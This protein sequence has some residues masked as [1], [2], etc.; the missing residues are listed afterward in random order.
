LALQFHPEIDAEGLKDWLIWGGDKNVI[1]DGQDP[2]IMLAQTVAEEEASKQ[3]TFALI[4]GFLD[5]V[6]NV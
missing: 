6:V 3:R 4:D 5:H 1:A 2:E